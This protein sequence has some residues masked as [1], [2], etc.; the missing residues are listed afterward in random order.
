[1]INMKKTIQIILGIM[2]IIIA[3]YAIFRISPNIDFTINFLTISFGLLALIWAIKAYKSLAPNSSLK[4]YSL[5]F[6]LALTLMVFHRILI[7]LGTLMTLSSWYNYLSYLLIT[8]SYIL[9]VAA[10]YKILEIG[11]EFGFA[12]S[13]SL[14]KEALK[15]RKKKK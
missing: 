2:S 11:K 9:F 14:I 5:L 10:G 12:E 1:M 4:K 13:T 15:E 6:A 7:I 3:I 8:L